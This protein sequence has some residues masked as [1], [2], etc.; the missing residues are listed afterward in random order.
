MAIHYAVKYIH[1]RDTESIF[2]LSIAP[3]VASYAEMVVAMIFI[4]VVVVVVVEVVVV[5]DAQ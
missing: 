3:T 1:F 2:Y 4:A 5:M